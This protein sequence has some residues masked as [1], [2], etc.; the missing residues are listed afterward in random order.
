MTDSNNNTNQHIDEII[1]DSQ[2]VKT[3]PKNGNIVNTKC[4]GLLSDNGKNGKYSNNTF[5]SYTISPL[6]ASQI[7]IQFLELDM[8]NSADRIKIFDGPN[9][10]SPLLVT[11][12]GSTIPV[13]PI[14]STGSSITIQQLSD[15]QISGEGFLLKW[16]CI[17]NN[18]P[19]SAN[20]I[21]LDSSSCSATIQFFNKSSGASQN[22]WYFGD[23]QNSTEQHPLHTYTQN[24]FYNIKLVASNYN[25]VD[26]LIKNNYIHINQISSP[27]VSDQIRCNSGSLTFNTQNNNTVY[28]FDNNTSNLPI[29][30]GNQFTTSHIQNTRSYFT[31]Q[32]Q[33]FTPLSLG[34]LDSTGFGSY[35]NIVGKKGLTFDV[36]IDSKLMSV[37]VYANSKGNRT[38]ML[39]NS[40]GEL[41]YNNT[42]DLS[43]GKN[44]IILNWNINKGI[45]YKIITSCNPDLFYNTNSIVFPYT[46]AT[47]N[48]TIKNSDTTS[49]YLYFYNWK[50]Q[51]KSCISPR[52]EVM[53]IISDTLKPLSA[54]QIISNNGNVDFDNQSEYAD[55]YY[56]DF[57]DGD[58]SLLKNPTHN[59]LYN[60]LYEVTL[61]AA[62]SCGNRTKTKYIQITNTSIEKSKNIVNLE[63]YPNPTSSVL[64]VIFESY[65]I[66]NANISIYNT[67]GQQIYMHSIE[68]SEAKQ[69]IKIQTNKYVKGV[70]ILRIETKNTIVQRKI[71]ID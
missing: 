45:D 70:Y 48:I 33:Y 31:S 10:N 12:Y 6:G 9:T 7:S 17:K 46:D 37:D 8:G 71:V 40:A 29:D 55:T 49:T 36:N 51:N 54:F 62:N 3:L 41:I 65:S 56:W 53:A 67:I 23:G 24:G 50:L 18:L 52:I 11:I 21:S 66:N 63:V 19:P 28:W 20:F 32:R 34:K 26:S 43:I 61:M 57:G 39:I 2:C 64:N 5:G 25:G 60:G 4:N 38:I 22:M 59:Y 14:V 68:L 16:Q 47:H 35:S 13:T 69:K 1:V 30:S 15:A 42:T 58:F 27:T 44:T